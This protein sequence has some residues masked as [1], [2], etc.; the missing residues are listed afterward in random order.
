[1]ATY[2]TGA[3]GETQ[4]VVTKKYKENWERIWGK[5]QTEEEDTKEHDKEPHRNL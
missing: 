3:K 2:K 1:M 5:K 4:K